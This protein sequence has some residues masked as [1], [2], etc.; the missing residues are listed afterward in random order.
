MLLPLIRRRSA[1]PS[2]RG[3]GYIKGRNFK[4]MRFAT[5]RYETGDARP[6]GEAYNKGNYLKI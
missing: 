5:V 2:P 4:F 6:W 1:T 3:E